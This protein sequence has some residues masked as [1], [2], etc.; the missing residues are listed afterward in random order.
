VTSIEMQHAAGAQS[1]DVHAMAI[2]VNTIEMQFVEWQRTV[3]PGRVESRYRKLMP[4]ADDIHSPG[5]PALV[6]VETDDA[7]ISGRGYIQHPLPGEHP[8]RIEQKR[9]SPGADDGQIRR[10]REQLGAGG[11]I[12]RIAVERDAAQP[13]SARCAAPVDVGLV[14]V[15]RAQDRL[16]LKVEHTDA[17]VDFATVAAANDGCCD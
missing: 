17:T 8:V 6:E 1:A 15:K 13:T 2:T 16:R 12:H 10:Q 5:K 4:F 14:P 7:V 3:V 11:D 9:A